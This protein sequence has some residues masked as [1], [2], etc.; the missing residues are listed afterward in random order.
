LSEVKIQSVL[1]GDAERPTEMIGPL[2]SLPSQSQAVRKEAWVV[3]VRAKF[4]VG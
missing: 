4:L 3:T 1:R 2:G